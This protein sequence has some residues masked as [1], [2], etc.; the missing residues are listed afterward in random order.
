MRSIGC[1][2]L[3]QKWMINWYLD[4]ITNSNNIKNSDGQ[5]HL[6]YKIHKNTEFNMVCILPYM[7]WMWECKSPFGILKFRW[8]WVS[9]RLLHSLSWSKWRK[10]TSSSTQSVEKILTQYWIKRTATHLKNGSGICYCEESPGNFPSNI[11]PFSTKV[12]LM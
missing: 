4:N 1:T 12:P 7:D 10:P 5:N 3:S 6:P 2:Y 9:V 11:N 8:Y